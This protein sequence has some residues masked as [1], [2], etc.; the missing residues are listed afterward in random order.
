VEARGG[1]A[2]TSSTMMIVSGQTG[3]RRLASGEAIIFGL[4]GYS[5]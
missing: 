5:L 2:G 4:G 3:N 1:G